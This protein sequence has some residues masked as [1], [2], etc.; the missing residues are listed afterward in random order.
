MERRRSSSENPEYKNYKA[1][2]SYYFERI[3]QGKR[4]ER[5]LLEADPL[6]SE[7][8]RVEFEAIIE[9]GNQAYADLIVSKLPYIRAVARTLFSRPHYDIDDLVQI[10]TLKLM[11]VIERFDESRGVPLLAFANQRIKGAMM[12][13]MAKKEVEVVGGELPERPQAV[14]PEPGDFLYSHLFGRLAPREKE[15]LLLYTIA[16]FTQAEISRRLGITAASVSRTLGSAIAKA[17][18]EYDRISTL[19]T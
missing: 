6:V 4:A 18:A 8:D 1:E 10:G 5:V 7:E 15:I 13:F 2:E 14:Y 16:N 12:D 19:D 3:T 9:A 17:R 11:E